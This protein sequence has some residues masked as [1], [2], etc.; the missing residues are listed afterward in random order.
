MTDFLR[1][2]ERVEDGVHLD[3][4]DFARALNRFLKLDLGHATLQAIITVA[5][6]STNGE[7]VF[8]PLDPPSPTLEAGPFQPRGY[9]RRASTFM[10]KF[11]GYCFKL[12][13][14]G[15]GYYRDPSQGPAWY[16]QLQPSQQQDDG[17]NNPFDAWSPLQPLFDVTGVG[18][19]PKPYYQQTPGHKSPSSL[20]AANTNNNSPRASPTHRQS[21]TTRFVSGSENFNSMNATQFDEFAITQQPNQQSNGRMSGSFS[22]GTHEYLPLP[23][24]EEEAYDELLDSARSAFGRMA[25]GVVQFYNLVNN[26]KRF[27]VTP[28]EIAA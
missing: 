21:P 9:F 1:H 3:S 13:D 10:G 17:R 22:K 2:I 14:R 28:N 25:L 11:S 15:L 26:K 4:N 23:D 6:K 16:E 18:A 12:D 7:V 8:T 27:F 24:N 20:K 5:E 19:V